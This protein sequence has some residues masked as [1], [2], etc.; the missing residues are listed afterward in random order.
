VEGALDTAGAVL[1]G[2]WY[3][4]DQDWFDFLSAQG[5]LD[6]VNYWQP[7]GHS[8]I[9]SLER[10]APFFFKLKRPHNHIVGFGFFDRH[11][12]AS[13]A[14]AWEAF[15]IA[16]GAPDLGTMVRRIERYRGRA[17]GDLGADSIGCVMVQEPVF[18]PRDLWIP[19]PSAWKVQGATK[20]SGVNMATDEARALWSR[21]LAAAGMTGGRQPQKREIAADS[22]MVT[23]RLIPRKGQGPFRL[24]LFDAYGHACAVS[25]EH[26]EPVL[27]AA[28][29]RPYADE[30]TYEVSNGLLLRTDIHRL[31]ESGYVGVTPD[32]EFEVSPRLK[33]LW[34]NGK[35]Y[36]ELAERVGRIRVPSRNED[37][38][39]RDLLAQH[40][41]ERFKK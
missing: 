41:R 18:L 9:G 5:K 7:S 24:A 40:Y 27:D 4:T 11:P 12:E 34:N 36:Y 33:E 21:C 17:L 2:Y 28:H 37:M 23:R 20:G 13:V 1:R 26:S 14:A 39:D 15:G 30:R 19:A 38:P 31:F 25:G 3:P 6:E 29:I 16:N 10:G 22:E 35:T 8:A 32:Y